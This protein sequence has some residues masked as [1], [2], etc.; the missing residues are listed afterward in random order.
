MAS[1]A[2][3]D[4]KKMANAVLDLTPPSM[5]NTPPIDVSVTP[6]PSESDDPPQNEGFSPPVASTPERDKIDRNTSEEQ[7]C[8]RLQKQKSSLQKQVVYLRKMLVELR[9]QINVERGKVG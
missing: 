5:E 6:E 7:L 9:K 1:S 4:R 2:Y 8:K 3:R